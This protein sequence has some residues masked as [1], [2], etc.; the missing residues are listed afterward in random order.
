MR[1]SLAWFLIGG[2]G[3]FACGFGE[4]FCL[5]CQDIDFFGDLPEFFEIISY[6]S[7]F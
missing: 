4:L 7:Y 3:C 2:G 6:L 1:L 5:L